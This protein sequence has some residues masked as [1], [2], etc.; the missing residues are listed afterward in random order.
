M[1]L[2]TS[3]LDHVA[4]LSNLTAIAFNVIFGYHLSDHLSIICSISESVDLILSKIN[5]PFLLLQK[6]LQLPKNEV[7]ICLDIN[8]AE[9]CN[10]LCFA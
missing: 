3:N 8:W 1:S 4:V 5:V 2:F 6:S 10:A 9:I 7:L